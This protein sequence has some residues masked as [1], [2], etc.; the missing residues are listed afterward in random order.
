[1]S[2]VTGVSV[3][4]K[5]EP[6]DAESLGGGSERKIDVRKARKN[7]EKRIAFGEKNI[8]TRWEK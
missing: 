6:R 3:M 8:F 1:M 4:A 5:F 2:H 7:Y